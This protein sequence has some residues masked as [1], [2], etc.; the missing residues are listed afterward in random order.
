MRQ[1]TF[2]A[3]DSI[4]AAEPV[5]RGNS[6]DSNPVKGLFHE[7]RELSHA[8]VAGCLHLVYGLTTLA[9]FYVVIGNL[10]QAR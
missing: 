8:L 5:K 7:D 2:V 3:A 4:G 6:G 10:V 1:V 9:F